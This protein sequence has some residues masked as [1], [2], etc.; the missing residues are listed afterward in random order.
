MGI[1]KR[2]S[3]EVFLVLMT[4]LIIASAV[5][6]NDYLLKTGLSIFSYIVIFVWYLI[7]GSSLND[8]LPDTEYK[9]DLLFKINCFYLLGF[10]SISVILR[11]GSEPIESEMPLYIVAL[12]LYYVFAFLYVIYFAASSYIKVLENENAP[13]PKS[14]IVYLSFLVIFL[15]VWVL[16]PQLKKVFT[17]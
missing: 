14:E 11:D 8:R 15:G 10:L 5:N 16:Q 12:L 2:S 9:S 6:E 4:P 7:V 17:S 3:W 1:L 13:R